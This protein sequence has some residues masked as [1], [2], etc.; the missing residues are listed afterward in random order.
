MF[1]LRSINFRE[2]YL[3]SRF[4]ITFITPIF[5][6]F[7][8]KFG[9]VFLPLTCIASLTDYSKVRTGCRACWVNKVKCKIVE[10]SFERFIT[11]K[12]TES[13]FVKFPFTLKKGFDIINSQIIAVKKRAERFTFALSMISDSCPYLYF[14]RIGVFLLDPF[15]AFTGFTNCFSIFFGR[16]VMPKGI[17]G[18]SEKMERVL[19]PAPTANFPFLF[20]NIII[21]LKS[22]F[23]TVG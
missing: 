5:G 17:E 21:P 11:V 15:P 23:E 20:H 2:I 7:K 18:F 22:S 14:K 1:Y 4:K 10:H 3:N 8:V 13:E 12:A 9:G 19:N 16:R 6:T